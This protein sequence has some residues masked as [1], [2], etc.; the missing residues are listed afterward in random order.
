MACSE[1]ARRVAELDS[2]TVS[3]SI[4]SSPWDDILHFTSVMGNIVSYGS[5]QDAI[6]LETVTVADADQ[7]AAGSRCL[8]RL[9]QSAPELTDGPVSAAQCWIATGSAA[10][11]P[12]RH[13]T[14]VLSHFVD[15]ASAGNVMPS[16][17]PFYLGMFTSTA[18][19]G[20]RSTWRAYLDVTSPSTLHPRPWFTWKLQPDV[21]A[22]VYE[23]TTASAW[24]RLVHDN[25][26]GDRGLLYPDWGQIA[27]RFDAVHLTMPAVLALQGLMI[28][29]EG[30][31]LAPLFW[32][33]E[34]TFW[35][36]WRFVSTELCEVA[37]ARDA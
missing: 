12:P 33:A 29:T 26:I 28:R 3:S 18:L 6:R 25:P 30:G 21:N 35:L 19:P 20:G 10:H 7:A 2:L 37:Y 23:V 17:K 22:R 15:I 34:S 11:R 4:A 24:S 13:S 31:T 32:D 27:K 8:K 9:K 1:L 16:T 5:E 14:P 36:R